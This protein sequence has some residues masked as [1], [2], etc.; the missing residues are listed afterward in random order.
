MNLSLKQGKLPMRFSGLARGS[1]W[2]SLVTAVLAAALGSTASLTACGDSSQCTKT[3]NQMF[4]KKQQWG[5]CDPNDPEPCIKVPGNTHDCS[6]ALFCDFAVNPAHRIEAEQTVLTIG[7]ETQGCYLCAEP[8]CVQGDLVVCEP[9][10]RQCI[11]V[12]SIVDA[13]GGPTQTIDA[14]IP[15]FPIFDAN[16]AET[17]D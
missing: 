6:G 4:A 17:G 3:R 1:I 2:L 10:S 11:V 15:L 13:G 9:V 5:A 16:T 7:N 12:T 8:N 14:S